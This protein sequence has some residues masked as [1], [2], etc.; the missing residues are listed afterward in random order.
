[1]FLP[2]QAPGVTTADPDILRTRAFMDILLGIDSRP[3]PGRPDAAPVRVGH[4]GAGGA[5][6]DEPRSPAPAGPPAGVIPPGFAGLVTRTIP[7]ATLLGL[8]DR[9]GEMAGIGP[10][11]PD[12]G[13]NTQD[14]YQACSLA[15]PLL[16]PKIGRHHHYQ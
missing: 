15:K 12:P 5:G 7:A 16:W 3:R 1:V 11:D 9:P 13:A 8:A 4:G 10:I 6:P 2:R 14:R